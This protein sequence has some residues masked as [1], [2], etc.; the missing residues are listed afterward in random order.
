MMAHKVIPLSLTRGPVICW[1]LTVWVLAGKQRLCLCEDL[2]LVEDSSYHWCR[3][4]QGGDV[5]WQGNLGYASKSQA[6][7]PYWE[8][9]LNPLIVVHVDIGHCGGCCADFA[10]YGSQ[11]IRT[12]IEG[13][14]A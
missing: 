1:D 7:F 6:P 10:I 13:S 4:V 14:C 8:R 3:F 2:W 5:T 9:G 12:P 11:A